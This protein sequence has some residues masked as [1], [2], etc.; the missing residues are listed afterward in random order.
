[1]T[2]FSVAVALA[3]LAVVPSTSAAEEH[4]LLRNQ[5]VASAIRVLDSWIAAALADRQW[6]G[7]AIGI[8]HDQDLVWAKGYG[9]A[10]LDR[11]APATPATVFRIASI[12]K[13]FT[14]T[15]V[16]QLRDAGKL[17]LDEPV[18]T[19]LPWF[20][21]KNAH[22]EGP[23]ITIRHLLTH[24]SGLPRELGV[25]SWNDL[26]FAAPDEMRRALA[27]TPSVYAAGTTWKYS[28]L[29]Y[30]ILGEVVA[31][32][33][34]EPW[35]AYIDAHILK[36]LGMTATRPVPAADTP[37]LAVSYGLRAGDGARGAV[38]FIGLDWLA[39]AGS[40]VSTVEDLARWVAFQLRDRPAGGA[41]V[42]GGATL[43]EMRRVHWLQSDWQNGWGLGFAIRRAGTETR[44]GH[45]GLLPGMPTLV[46]VAPATKLGVIAL[47]NAADFTTGRV[48][49]QAFSVLTGPIG[50]AT[51]KREEAKPN[52][53]WDRFV[54][55]YV[56]PHWF[57]AVEVMVVNGQL[58]LVWPTSD[59]PMSGRVRL[60]Q[61]GADTFRMTNGW[62]SGE[63]VTFEI[64]ARGN[65]TRLSVAASYW[66]RK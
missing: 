35:A 15:A 37:G 24:T 18:T 49:D 29:G 38:P 48:V 47:G 9:L 23:A 66:T 7:L 42:L 11:K 17:K 6:P 34:G 40:M 54:G 56:G 32:V 30:A 28:N 51:E 60:R 39:P 52:P 19:Y 57:P 3:L 1:M 21:Y 36:P 14:A 13:T 65:V 62:A 55:T 20:Q 25:Y 16:M 5:E 41:Q 22:T 45:G 10:D 2:R 4:A 61:L 8:V 31:A 50:R 12:S 64:D 33:S 43:R 46:S 26:T 53:A 63:I 44:F 58:A 59:A 27:Q